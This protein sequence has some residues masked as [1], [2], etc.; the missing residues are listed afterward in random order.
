MLA[1]VSSL[2]R[3]STTQV[4]RLG[5][6]GCPPASRRLFSSSRSMPHEIPSLQYL[7]INGKVVPLPLRSMTPV[8]AN[9]I[10]YAGADT[11]D[12][13]FEVEGKRDED[14]N[15]AMLEYARLRPALLPSSFTKWLTVTADGVAVMTHSEQEGRSIIERMFPRGEYH[16]DCLG[17]EVLQYVKMDSSNLGFDPTDSTPPEGPGVHENQIFALAE[18]SFGGGAPFQQALMKHDT[19]AQ[20]MGIPYEVAANPPA[21]LILERDSINLSIGPGGGVGKKGRSYKNQYFR[22]NGL[23]TKTTVVET[24]EWFIG[25]P[26][27]SR[28]RTVIDVSS[29]ASPLVM[30]PLP[31][32]VDHE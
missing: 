10:A 25:F 3:R 15:A 29:A 9:Q 21:G 8:N 16:I 1:V 27:I 6:S 2:C 17:C 22:L 28:Y 19:G 32:Q 24:R 12:V 18:H 26:V 31:G 23:V 30:T 4:M 20:L 5:D 14:A 13:F 11:L 7:Q